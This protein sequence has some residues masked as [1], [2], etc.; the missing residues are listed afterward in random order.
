MNQKDQ[1]PSKRPV[2]SSPEQLDQLLQVAN[3]GGWIALAALCL[4]LITAVVWSVVGRI[5]T[6]V[7]GAG[8]IIR[9]GGVF[10]VVSLGQG[11]LSSLKLAPGDLVK[12]GQVVAE[13]SQPSLQ[14]QI[15]SSEQELKQLK[16]QQATLQDFYRT[17]DK[18]Q[19]QL[20]DQR[21]QGALATIADLDMR[22]QWL[23]KRIA[24]QQQLLDKGLITS[25]TLMQTKDQLMSVREQKSQQQTQLKNLEDQYLKYQNQ[26][27]RDLAQ[28]DLSILQ[29]QGKLELLRDEMDLRA[30]IR[31]KY[32]GRVL[33]IK[34]NVGL[35]VNIGTPLFSLELL[36]RNLLAVAYAPAA[37]GKLIEDGMRIEITPSTV[38]RDQYGFMIGKVTSVSP[39]PATQQGMMAVL[40]NQDLVREFA[41][42][43]APMTV[44]AELV[45][46]PKTFSGFQWSSD[47][48]PPQ[49]IYSGTVCTVQVVVDEQPPINLVIPYFKSVFGL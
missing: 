49:K 4:V 9:S 7:D 28:G 34:A 48:G 40:Q 17:Q 43:G 12:N 2:F 35:E 5:P 33:E 36:D 24:D 11:Q 19:K 25:Q 13:L 32:T 18:L 39:F 21:R 29:A 31:S 22:S 41:A 8:I 1:P 3:P 47:N 37:H 27:E 42:G 38:K 26:R 46:N 6:K 20:S 23:N 45:K 10:D 16:K 15:N 44:F 30:K 14:A